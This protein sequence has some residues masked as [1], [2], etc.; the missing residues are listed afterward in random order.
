MSNLTKEALIAELTAALENQTGKSV[1]I[2]QKG[3]WYKIDGGKSIRFSELEK[4]HLE[5]TQG[6]TAVAPVADKPVK[7]VVAKKAVAKKPAVKVA[8]TP[9]TS[10]SGGK[11]PKELWRE[12]LAAAGKSTLPRGF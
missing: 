1:E 3:S 4:M 9:A 7:A 12:K 8:S 2:E 5:A 10:T 11:T 6:Q